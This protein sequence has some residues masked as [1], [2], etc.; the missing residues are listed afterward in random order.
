MGRQDSF[1]ENSIGRQYL[2]ITRRRE[3]SLTSLV[4]RSGDVFN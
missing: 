4:A 2:K 1:E 3:I